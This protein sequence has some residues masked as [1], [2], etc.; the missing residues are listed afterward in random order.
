VVVVV[1]K[2]AFHPVFQVYDLEEPRALPS[3]AQVAT[4]SVLD[5]R[6]QR[7]S[8][9]RLVRF[10]VS[11]GRDGASPWCACH[12]NWYAY[13]DSS[14]TGPSRSLRV[15]NRYGSYTLQVQGPT[16]LLIPASK[17]LHPDGLVEKASARLPHFSVYR[18]VGPRLPADGPTV[19]LADQIQ[20]SKAQVGAPIALAVMVD[21]MDWPAGA[22]R[23]EPTLSGG[24]GQEG[25]GI[26]RLNPACATHA[27]VDADDYAFAHSKV[28]LASASHVAEPTVLLDWRPVIEP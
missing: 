7:A 25:L 15:G 5:S 23:S 13:A 27:M 11:A 16:G 1:A 3:G 28:A 2:G 26:H 6:L 24:P 17:R 8:L 18:V 20:R 12:L 4:R 19:G 21:E 10:I 9:T 14:R 22:T